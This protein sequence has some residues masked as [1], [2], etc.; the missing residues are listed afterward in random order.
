M[1]I[2]NISAC[3]F[4][5]EIGEPDAPADGGERSRL[6][7]HAIGPAWLR[8][9]FG[10]IM[11]VHRIAPIVVASAFFLSGCGNASDGSGE[12]SIWH[13]VI[14]AV[15]GAFLGTAAGVAFTSNDADYQIEPLSRYTGEHILISGV[16]FAVGCGLIGYC[17]WT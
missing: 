1:R 12:H 3:E 10:G 2:R 6:H 14:S 13:G 8:F 17:F 9:P 15:I 5:S 4:P 7:S 11:H 16:S